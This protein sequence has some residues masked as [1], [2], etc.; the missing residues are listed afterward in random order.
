MRD[1]YLTQHLHGLFW[2]V[3]SVFNRPLIHAKIELSSVSNAGSKE[4]VKEY[5]S[6]F[7]LRCQEDGTSP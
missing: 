7:F 1:A 2:L 5:S 3:E 4:R 6:I